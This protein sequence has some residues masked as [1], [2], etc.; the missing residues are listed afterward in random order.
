MSSVRPLAQG[1]V[2]LVRFPI[3]D[4]AIALADVWADD[5]RTRDIPSPRGNRCNNRR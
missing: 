5:A 4:L 2:I 3:T 1:D